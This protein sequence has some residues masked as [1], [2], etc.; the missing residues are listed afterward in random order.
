MATEVLAHGHPE[1]F[2]DRVAQR[3]RLGERESVAFGTGWYCNF[4][5]SVAQP[6][7]VVR[8]HVLRCDGRANAAL[9]VVA[10]EGT[11][12]LHRTVESLGAVAPLYAPLLDPQRDPA[13]LAL[14]PA[15]RLASLVPSRSIVS[16]TGS[17]GLHAT[18]LRF[19]P[20]AIARCAARSSV[21]SVPPQR[22]GRHDL[23]TGQAVASLVGFSRPSGSRL[24]GALR[25]S[26]IHPSD[27]P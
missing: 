18:D 7:E 2:L 23:R 1:E 25:R 4:V 27:P 5:E 21:K 22:R 26:P 15:I 10:S 14:P 12:P 6:G 17:R 9:P 20:D 13:R 11:L 16:S 8:F 24:D 3:V 19:F